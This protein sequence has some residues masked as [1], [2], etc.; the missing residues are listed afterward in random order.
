MAPVP[1]SATEAESG[2]CTGKRTITLTSDTTA[3]DPEHL[4]GAR[5][6]E[7]W[8]KVCFSGLSFS[9][10]PDS[11]SVAQKLWRPRNL[12]LCPSVV[13]LGSLVT[14]CLTPMN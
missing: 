2:P 1:G 13:A 12:W 10:D 8:G 6:E 3:Q 9:G 11:Q 5:F 4:P 14:N 7:S